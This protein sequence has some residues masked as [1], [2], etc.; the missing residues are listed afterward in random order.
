MVRLAAGFAHQLVAELEL[1]GLATET[2]GKVFM[3]SLLEQTLQVEEQF[4]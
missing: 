2:A 4:H 3:A 1:Q